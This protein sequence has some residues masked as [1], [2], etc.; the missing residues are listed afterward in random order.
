MGRERERNGE[1]RLVEVRLIEILVAE[2]M[3]GVP[4]LIAVV[5]AVSGGL[6]VRVRGMFRLL[7]GHARRSMFGA[8]RGQELDRHGM[9]IGCRKMGGRGRGWVKVDQKTLVRQRKSFW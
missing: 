2:V 3:Y 7:C 6:G 1:F 5:Q 4:C 8:L 9:K